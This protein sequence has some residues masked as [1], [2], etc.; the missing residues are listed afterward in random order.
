[1]FCLCAYLQDYMN[2][3]NILVSNSI[4]ILIIIMHVSLQ[5][6]TINSKKK[7][8]YKITPAYFVYKNK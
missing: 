4:I 7:E 3:Q 2:N 8:K 6:K 5:K 1:M